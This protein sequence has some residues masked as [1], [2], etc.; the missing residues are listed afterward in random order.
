MRRAVCP[1]LGLGIALSLAGCGK[2]QWPHRPSGTDEASCSV[3]DERGVASHQQPL[4]NSVERGRTD[5]VR[6]LLKKGANPNEGRELD[7]TPLLAAAQFGHVEEAQLLIKAGADVNFDSGSG[8]PLC[9]ALQNQRA[10]IDMVDLL[11]RSGARLTWG[12]KSSGLGCL[13]DYNG[14]KQKFEYLISKGIV[15][16]MT[17]EQ[18]DSALADLDWDEMRYLVLHGASP[19]AI[20]SQGRTPLVRAVMNYQCEMV[21]FLLTRGA[22][23]GVRDSTGRTA[24]GWAE[25]AEL[26]LEQP[27]EKRSSTTTSRSLVRNRAMIRMLRS[28]TLSATLGCEDPP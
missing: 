24:L 19:N 2:L 27:V 11:V 5:C 12:T 25:S 22:D 15:D 14:R 20:D 7:Y 21:K 18:K 3:L 13:G 10:G 8:T 28:P 26:S 16:R 1:L 6:Y 4:T 17:Q 23:V 9:R